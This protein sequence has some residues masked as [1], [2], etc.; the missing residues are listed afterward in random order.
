MKKLVAPDETRA[1]R[2]AIKIW[3][4]LQ[5][6]PKMLERLASIEQDFNPSPERA[7][8]IVTDE[9]QAWEDRME[10]QI[11]RTARCMAGDPCESLLARGK[12]RGAGSRRRARR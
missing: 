6:L 8:Q 10:A 11:A 5:R 2:Q 9:I 3:K 4:T 12:R 7:R 1:I